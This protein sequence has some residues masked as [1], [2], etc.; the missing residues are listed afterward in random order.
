MNEGV[1][2]AAEMEEWR[3]RKRLETKYIDEI[4]LDIDEAIDRAVKYKQEGK[5]LSI[6]VV[7]NA[8]DLL[9]RMIDRGITPDTLTDQTS[10][11][12]E[13]IGYFPEKLSV[14][15]AKVLRNDN[16]KK[17]IELSLDTMVKHVQLMIELQ[18]KG[19]ITFDYGNNLRGQALAH[20]LKNAF[21]CL[22]YNLF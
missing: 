20:G 2:L 19:A 5:A 21:S 10:A 22:H 7:C 14:E 4:S 13:L 6:G 16:P 15:E 8:V 3:I 18:K 1:C 11:H 9:Q 17:Y 12:D